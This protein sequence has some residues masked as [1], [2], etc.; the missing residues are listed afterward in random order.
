[1]IEYFYGMTKNK[2]QWTKCAVYF[3][4][5]KKCWSLKALN[6]A[7]KGRVVAHIPKEETFQLAAGPEL[8]QIQLKVSKAGRERVLREKKKNVHAFV[9]GY[10]IFDL[11]FR[12]YITA[13]YNPYKYESFV[14]VEEKPIY[15]ANAAEFVDGRLLLNQNE[16]IKDAYFDVYGK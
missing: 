15:E 12:F 1:M 16:A 6:G 7:N 9:V 3:N 2:L 8:P 4:L 14:D 10:P 5:H 11:C 13:T